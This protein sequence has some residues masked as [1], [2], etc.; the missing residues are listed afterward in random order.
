MRIVVLLALLLS[1]AAV[2]QAQTR[3]PTPLEREAEE[4][5]RAL[6]DAL[7]RAMRLM[8]G[9]LGSIPQYQL[10]EVLPNGDIIIRR[11]PTPKAEPPTRRAPPAPE[12]RP[13]PGA[14]KLEET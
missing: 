14:P 12:P 7:E 1:C 5:A 8:D 6:R 10:P 9:V 3:P 4:T 13:A 2:A 11:I